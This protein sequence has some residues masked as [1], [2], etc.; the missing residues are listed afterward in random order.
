[1]SYANSE[2][3][4]EYSSTS[5]YSSS[6]EY[7]STSEAYISTTE[8]LHS[9]TVYSQEYEC[10]M[11][12]MPIIVD[13]RQSYNV[14]LDGILNIARGEFSKQKYFGRIQ[15]YTSNIQ[16]VRKYD[17]DIKDTKLRFSRL[18]LKYSQ[19]T[20]PHLIHCEFSQ[21]LK[22]GCFKIFSCFEF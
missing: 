2:S 15:S 21:Y 1:M 10:D 12:D 5:E 16:R 14:T 8:S 19:K 9:S 11:S 20:S 22:V 7:S 6:S 13:S 18:K 4:S 3:S 17:V